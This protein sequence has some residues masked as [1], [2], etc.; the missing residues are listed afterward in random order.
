MYRKLLL[1]TTGI[2]LLVLFHS[3]VALDLLGA[4][5]IGVGV[6]CCNIFKD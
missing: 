4:M 3:Y 2:A 1:T 5:L 6:G